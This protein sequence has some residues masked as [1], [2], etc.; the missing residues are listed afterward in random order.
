MTLSAKKLEE[1]QH[2][3][4]K[5][6][7]HNHA[8]QADI[9][10]AYRRLS[11]IYHPDKPN[12]NEAEFKAISAASR[13]LLTPIDQIANSWSDR[14]NN[15]IFNLHMLCT[16]ASDSQDPNFI[17][18]AHS[19]NLPIVTKLIEY[20][21]HILESESG[22]VPTVIASFG[23]HHQETQQYILDNAYTLNANNYTIYELLWLHAKICSGEVGLKGKLTFADPTINSRDQYLLLHIIH[24][25]IEFHHNASAYVKESQALLNTDSFTSI[26]IHNRLTILTVIQL[27]LYTLVFTAIAFSFS[28]LSALALIVAAFFAINITTTGLID[29]ITISVVI[30]NMTYFNAVRGLQWCKETDDLTLGNMQNAFEAKQMSREEDLEPR[31]ESVCEKISHMWNSFFAVKSTH[32]RKDVEREATNTSSRRSPGLSAGAACADI[33]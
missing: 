24:S 15:Y 10:S 21:T 7:L 31:H 2:A 9:R 23:V 3:L 8:T 29:L 33:D 22:Y 27:S 6:G 11:L 16:L 4:N 13:L 28:M 19:R 14:D 32:Q 1:R 26:F 12:G 17:P 5:L 25:H 18:Y 20:S 30:P